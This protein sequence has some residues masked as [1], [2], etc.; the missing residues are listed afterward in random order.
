MVSE[1]RVRLVNHMLRSCAAVLFEPQDWVVDAVGLGGF[2]QRKPSAH[3]VGKLRALLKAACGSQYRQGSH[4]P[5]LG[6]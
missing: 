5:D 4:R 1:P 6:N 3:T 2:H